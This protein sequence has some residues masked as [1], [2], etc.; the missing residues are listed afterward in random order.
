MADKN[1]TVVDFMTPDKAS[2][3]RRPSLVV[4]TERDFGR[5]YMLPR[6]ETIIGRDDDC[7]IQLQDSRVSRRH[8]K[9]VGDPGQKSGPYF[10]VIDLESTNGTFL[11]DERIREASL[12][13]GDRIHIGYTVFKYVVREASEI[14]YENKI[15]RMATTDA[16][17]GLFSREYFMQQYNDSLNRSERY[18]RPFSLVLADLDDFKSVNDTY[19]H[20]T[21][22]VVLETVGRMIMNVVRREDSAARYGGEEFSILLPETTPSK[23]KYPAERLR[24]GLEGHRFKID[25][26]KFSLTISIGIAGFP[27]HASNAEELIEKAD[28]ALYEA[29]R[30]GKNQIRIFKSDT[31]Q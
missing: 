7:L 20:P 31:E 29:K 4:V 24:A 10:K 27:E 12:N 21:G 14:D 30:A 6:G 3:E 26:N 15:Y 28:R 17:T 23:A 19:G 9:L 1:T 2:D 25:D 5:Q 16:L 22:D 8:A 18:K 13:D 11:N